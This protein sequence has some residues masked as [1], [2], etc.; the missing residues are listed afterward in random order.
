MAIE[1]VSSVGIGATSLELEPARGSAG[2]PAVTSSGPSFA[3]TLGEVI[4]NGIGVMQAGEA[5]AIQGLQGTAPP[6][7]VVEAIMDAQRT[8]QQTL[9]IRDKAVS[10]YQEIS[11]MTI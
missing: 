4:N 11:R 7:K 2:A 5:A 6:F 10:A 1:S 9:S 3:Q 8:L